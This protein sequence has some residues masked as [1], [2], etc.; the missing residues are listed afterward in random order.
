MN[1]TML[2]AKEYIKAAA[3]AA[4]VAVLLLTLWFASD[5]VLLAFAGII[6]AIILCAASDFLARIVGVPRGVGLALTCVLLVAAV[7]LFGW[8]VGPRLSHEVD[9]LRAQIPSAWHQLL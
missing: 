9:E 7:A 2:G 1:G 5:V 6:L 8:F 3:C 4:A